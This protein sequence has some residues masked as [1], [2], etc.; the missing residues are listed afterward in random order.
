MCA[1]WRQIWWSLIWL[2]LR[3]GFSAGHKES[4][5]LLLLLYLLL[6][7]T[8]I[9]RGRL[10][11]GAERR[12]RRKLAREGSRDGSETLRGKHGRHPAA[13]GRRRSCLDA[14]TQT[15]TL[16]FWSENYFTE[17]IWCYDTFLINFLE[18]VRSGDFQLA[19]RTFFLFPCFWSSHYYF[20]F[21]PIFILCWVE[22]VYFLNIFSVF[23][24]DDI[25]FTS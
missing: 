13:E 22:I 14:L 12:E 18:F 9:W 21:I 17:P 10:W 8:D 2:G 7:G 19:L 16:Q 23:F 1:E 24:V 20:L 3:R 11:D 6:R 25:F 15:Q 5:I 4:I